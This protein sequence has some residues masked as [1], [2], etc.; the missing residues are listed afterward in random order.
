MMILIS[1]KK[2]I[3]LGNGNKYKTPAGFSDY[4]LERNY[5]SKDSTDVVLNVKVSRH[6]PM[7]GLITGLDNKK[8]VNVLI[9]TQQPIHI[10]DAVYTLSHAK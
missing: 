1:I 8:P 6:G 10:L 5:K 3:V 2:R 4:Q 7:N 9:Y